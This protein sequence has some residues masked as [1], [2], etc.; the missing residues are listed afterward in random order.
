MSRILRDFQVTKPTRCSPKFPGYE[1]KIQKLTRF[2]GY[3]T[4]GCSPKFSGYGELQ[5]SEADKVYRLCHFQTCAFQG[6]QVMEKA[7]TRVVVYTVVTVVPRDFHKYML[8][9]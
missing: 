8:K 7:P 3:A 9:M 4:Q 5:V 2:S 1:E 6:V